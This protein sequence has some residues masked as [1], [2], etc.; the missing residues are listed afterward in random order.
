MSEHVPLFQSNS[1]T[2]SS[3]AVLK[4]SS[5]N[6]AASL[7][8]LDIFLNKPEVEDLH[9]LRRMATYYH[10]LADQINTTQ[11]NHMNGILE[12]PA[13]SSIPPKDITF[14]IDKHGQNEHGNK[15]IHGIHLPLEVQN[16]K[17]N[18]VDKSKGK[19]V[20]DFEHEH[21]R[22][23]LKEDCDGA[24]TKSSKKRNSEQRRRKLIS[25]KIQTLQ[26][27]I[28]HSDKTDQASILNDAIN[29]IKSLKHVIEMGQGWSAQNQVQQAPYSVPTYVPVM[30]KPNVK[31]E[32][33]NGNHAVNLCPMSTTVPAYLPNSPTTQL[34]LPLPPPSSSG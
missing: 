26:H 16:L 22:Q 5:S 12:C 13:G 18:D 1:T 8:N 24:P 20:L 27:L 31:L 6:L 15:T 4:T 34:I 2:S 25:E 21:T 28:P 3:S 7:A 17:E 23:S 19:E 10:Q 30:M 29:H 33:M 32:T 11:N 14:P 9:N